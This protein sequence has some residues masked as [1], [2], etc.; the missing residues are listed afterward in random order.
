MAS[1]PKK[2]ARRALLKTLAA[3]PVAGVAAMATAAPQNAR[4][5]TRFA[6]MDLRGSVTATDHGLVAGAIDDQSRQFQAVLERAAALD[7]PVFLPPGTYFVSNI[8]LPPTTRL[9]GVPGASRLVYSG[10]GHFLISENGR[11]IEM[12][13]IVADG[14]NRGLNSYAEAAVRVS[15]SKQVVIDNCQITGSLERGLQVDRSSGRVERSSISGAMGDCGIYALENRGLSIRDNEVGNCSNGGILVH[16]W[17]PGEDGTIV[18]GNRIRDIGATNGGTGQW[19]NGINVFR[20]HSVLIANNQIAD[21]AF[22]A[23]RSNGGSNVQISANQCLRSGETAIY[24]EFEF[25]GAMIANN[26]VDGATTGIS[27]ANFMQGGRMAVCAN[28]I[29]RNIHTDAPYEEDAHIFGLGISVEADTTVTGNVVEQVANF[30]LQLGWGPYLRDVVATSN[31]IRKSRTGVYVSVVEGARNTVISDNVISETTDGA[32]I[33][34]R[35]HDKETGDLA[36]GNGARFDHLSI[37]R[38]RVS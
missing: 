38:N 18:M 26:V 11:H 23:I 32:I 8:N 29:V 14:A 36:G 13:G 25:V 15:N 22:S 24:S 5:E 34:Y 21:C 17:T 20:A 1:N 6:N 7:K 10:G 31:V 30:G 9:I 19:G 35:W 28:N 3:A 27:I 33:G 16:R 2:L 4:G 37:E 12:T